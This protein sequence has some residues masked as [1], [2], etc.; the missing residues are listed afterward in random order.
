MTDSFIHLV[1]AYGLVP[2]VAP[3]VL[4]G[5]GVNNSVHGIHTGAGDVV[6][7]TYHTQDNVT[8]IAYEHDLLR[9]LAQAGLPFAV[10]TPLPARNGST[11]CDTPHGWQALFTW[12]PG[13][14]GTAK[15]A[16]HIV[17]AG[18]ALGAIH[19]VLTQYPAAPRPSVVAFGD[20]DHIHPHI[21]DPRALLS[22]QHGYDPSTHGLLVRW[23]H[24]EVRAVQMFVE[25]S[26]STLPTQIIHGDFGLGNLLFEEDNLTAVLDWEFAVLDVRA[27][28]IATLLVSMLF[29]NGVADFGRSAALLSHG[30][31]THIQLTT[32]EIAALPWLIR[33]WNAVNLIWWVGHDVAIGHQRP[34]QID[35]LRRAQETAHWLAYHADEVIRAFS[36]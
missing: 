20:L 9:W 11:I 30:Y 29:A 14:P 6:L 12:L 3:F 27:M 16:P 4:N 33:L 8:V 32:E 10:P 25:Q 22:R 13:T 17:A 24:T 18:H 36:A 1:D 21:P 28:D 7:K 5:Q 31:R 19:H 23:W 15:K 2:P 26:Y 34:S 35:R